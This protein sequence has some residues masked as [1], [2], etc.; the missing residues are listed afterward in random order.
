MACT[1]A[2]KLYVNKMLNDIAGMKVL[3]LDPTTTGIVSVVESQTNILQKDV[4][5]ISQLA[6]DKRSREQMRHLNAVGVSTRTA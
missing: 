5:L 2:V 4:F 3:L 1:S 6:R